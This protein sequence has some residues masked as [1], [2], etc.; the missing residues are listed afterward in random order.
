M[1]ACNEF[2]FLKECKGEA[3]TSA[4]LILSG[5]E[6]YEG[7]V[8]DGGGFKKGE[9]VRFAQNAPR[10]DVVIDDAVYLVVEKKFILCSL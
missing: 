7:V 6:K 8:V 5:Q 2:V 4:G 3:E 9:T 10:E 1:K